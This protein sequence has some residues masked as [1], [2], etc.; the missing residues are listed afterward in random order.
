MLTSALITMVKQHLLY[1]LDNYAGQTPTDLAIVGQ[2][3]WAQRAVARKIEPYDPLIGLTL[4]PSQLQHNL[5]DLAVV[6]KK[7]VRPEL[8]M[9]NGV[10]L[11]TRDQKDYGLWS[12][13]EL[14]SSCSTWFSDAAGT[15]TKAVFY[16]T[17]LILHPKPTSAFANSYIAGVY[18]PADLTDPAVTDATPDLPEEIHEALALMAALYAADPNVSEAEGLSRLGRYSQRAHDAI[19]QVELDFANARSAFEGSDDSYTPRFMS[20]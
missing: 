11:L 5:R 7:V 4:T 10:T 18:F 13:N 15:P 14:R 19:R 2:L 12:M 1:D 17:K 20:M 9:I 3:N 16:D 8:V 6:T